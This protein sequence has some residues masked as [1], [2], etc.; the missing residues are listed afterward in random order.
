MTE[1]ETSPITATRGYLPRRDPLERFEVDGHS[2][3][4]GSYLGGFDALGNA[5][6]SRLE[7]GTIESI[8][9]DLTSPPKGLFDQLSRRETIRV[10][11]ITAFLASAFVHETERDPVDRP[12]ASLA[13]PLYRSSRWLGRRPVLSYDLL[14]LHNFR[15]P[16]GGH[17]IWIDNLD[18]LQAFTSLEH[19]PGVT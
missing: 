8:D 10:C 13:R 18:T 1:I 5:L 19:S 15:R 11:R 4:I 6:P 3:E 12:P 17:E 16:D 7:G 14:C 2:S 9:E